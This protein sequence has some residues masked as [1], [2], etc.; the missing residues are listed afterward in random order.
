M[1]K[2]IVQDTAGRRESVAEYAT[3]AEALHAGTQHWE[4]YEWFVQGPP[5]QALQDQLQHKIDQL[6]LR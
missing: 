4:D 2:L 6:Y 1:F 3:Y 5:A